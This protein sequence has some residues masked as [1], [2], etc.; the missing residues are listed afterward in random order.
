MIYKICSSEAR[1][2]IFPTNFVY[3]AFAEMCNNQADDVCHKIFN[4]AQGY[5]IEKNDILFATYTTF[6][7]PHSSHL[8]L[9]YLK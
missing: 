6:Y 4:I 8:P 2:E 9:H 1:E 3:Y 5:Q 7:G